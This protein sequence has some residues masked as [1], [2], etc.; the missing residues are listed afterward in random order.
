MLFDFFLDLGVYMGSV[1][2]FEF[3]FMQSVWFCGYNCDDYF[4]NLYF[5]GVGIY[6]GVGILGVVGSV[7]VIVFLMI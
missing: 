1:F 4:S 6:F 5:V 3:V 2:S 7:K